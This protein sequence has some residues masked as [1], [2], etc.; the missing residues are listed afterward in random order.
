MILIGRGLDLRRESSEELVGSEEER[1]RKF[2]AEEGESM[3]RKLQPK[4]LCGF[5]GAENQSWSLWKG[6][7]EAIDGRSDGAKEG[8]SRRIQAPLGFR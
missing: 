6:S 8:G 2:R 3:V 1:M 4:R 7:R 5:E